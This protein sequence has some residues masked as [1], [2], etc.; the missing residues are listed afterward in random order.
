MSMFPCERT[1]SAPRHWNGPLNASFG[2]LDGS[3]GTVDGSFGTLDGS[4]GPV[5]GV[6]D[7]SAESSNV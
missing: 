2:T 5:N 6:A 4:F 3:F 7:T 1:Q